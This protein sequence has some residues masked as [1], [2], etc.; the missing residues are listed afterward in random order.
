MFVHRFRGRERRMSSPSETAN[1]EQPTV[2]ELL[3]T[4]ELSGV[5][6]RE[7]LAAALAAAPP[8]LTAKET[9]SGPLAEFLVKIGKLSRFQARKLLQ[10]TH[11]GLVLGPYQILA[12]LG[13]GGM[14][15][16][17]MARDGRDCRLVAL[18]VL[19][20][21]RAREE[22]RTRHRFLREME[23]NKLVAHPHLALTYE[24]GTLQD[25]HYIAM[26]FIPGKSLYRAVAEGGP[27]TVA[28]AARLLAEVAAALE[29]AHEK[30]L[31]HRDLKPSNIMI[32]PNDHAKVLDFG[33]AYVQGEEADIKVVGGYG[34]IVGTMDYISPEQSVDP[35]KV[36]ARSDIYSLGCTLYY[37]L[38]GQPPFP[39]GTSHEKRQRHRTEEPTPLWQLRA[40]LP[41][42]FVDLVHRLMAK[43]PAH[44]PP[45]AQAVRQELLSWAIEDL[46]L[47][48]DK[49]NDTNY[50]IAVAALKE[51]AND[52]EELEDIS[53]VEAAVEGEPQPLVSREESQ[54]ESKVPEQTN[55]PAGQPMPPWFLLSLILG[56]PSVLV[57]IC[58]LLA[59]LAW[60]VFRRH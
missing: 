20:A 44:R 24:V 22:E 38:T 9:S 43:D 15:A 14:G 1:I 34:Y 12:P 40:G 53:K 37:A 29:H 6:D 11:R 51:A 58:F 19:S 18:K 16:V 57:A 26:E 46:A 3:Q 39:G 49:P 48:L 4:I 30:G 25:V 8:E 35:T 13:K 23:L 32:T 5:L 21:R 33:L 56:I 7:Q 36:D 60:L 47:P 59:S 2:E 42:G 17:Y 55:P 41:T 31:I 10:G 52:A 50:R 54:S 27:L 45:S 28:R